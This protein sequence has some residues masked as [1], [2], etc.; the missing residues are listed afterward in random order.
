[1]CAVGFTGARCERI[2]N[3]CLSSPCRDNQGQCISAA[4]GHFQCECRL[5]FT[6]SLC[7]T[8]INPC[9]PSPCVRGECF[10]DAPGTSKCACPPAFTGRFCETSLQ[11]W[12][13]YMYLGGD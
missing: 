3:P 12:V 13:C 6:G 9:S 2:D 10:S 4:Y 11:V 5:G 1:V 8:A 7:E